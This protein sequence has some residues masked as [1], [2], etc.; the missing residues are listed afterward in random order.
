MGCEVSTLDI[1][2]DG[3]LIGGLASGGTDSLKDGT[4]RMSR[5]KRYG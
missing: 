2:G 3:L 1:R 4:G 5:K